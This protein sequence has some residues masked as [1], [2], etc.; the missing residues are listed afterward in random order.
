MEQI[1]FDPLDFEE[2][3]GLTPEAAR[4]EAQAARRAVIKAKEAEGHKCRA[5]TLTGQLRKY[6]AFG[7]PCGR[8]R[9][10]YYITVYPKESGGQ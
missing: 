5:W 10:V 4:K 8:T 9:N 3:M 2:R 7:Q 1:S 6:R